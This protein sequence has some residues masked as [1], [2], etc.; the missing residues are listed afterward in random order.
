MK[1]QVDPLTD[2]RFSKLVRH[3]AAFFKPENVDDDG[4]KT[5]SSAKV[6][7]LEFVRS[8]LPAYKNAK[9]CILRRATGIKMQDAAARAAAELAVQAAFETVARPCA[10]T[11]GSDGLKGGQIMVGC[12]GAG[13]RGGLQERDARRRA[14]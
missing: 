1:A 7:E 4:C 9:W 3:G 11:E 6:G 13:C 10:E 2:H 12:D 5:I 14:S 8:E